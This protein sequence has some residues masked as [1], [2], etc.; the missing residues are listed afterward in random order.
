MRY[1]GILLASLLLSGA[2]IGSGSDAEAR[3]FR[4]SQTPG[5]NLYSCG[6]CHGTPGRTQFG[7][8]VQ[9]TLVGGNVNWSAI[10]DLDSDGD[11]LTNGEEM[12]DPNGEWQE[13]DFANPRSNPAD[14]NNVPFPEGALPV[15]LN[16][17]ANATE[18]TTYQGQLNAEDADG[19]TVRFRLDSSTSDG[20]LNFDEATGAFTYTPNQDY[21]GT[22][23]FVVSAI[24]GINIVEYSIA[25]VV[26]AVNDEPRVV[27]EGNQDVDEN[28]TL[29]F[30]IAGSDVEDRVPTL[31]VTDLP[32]GATFTE[33]NGQF[34]WT[35]NYEQAGD[36]TVIATATDS[37]GAVTTEE[38]V[39]TVNNVN[40][41][42]TIDELDG[43]TVG[44]EGDT[45][46][47]TAAASDIDGDN[48]TYTW[49]FG[50]GETLS[51]VNLTEVS[52]LYPVDGALTVTLTVND[53][54][55]DVT[56]THNV[57]IQNVA[58][59]ASAGINLILNEGD[60][61]TTQGSFNDP[62]IGDVHTFN[63]DFGNGTT[64]NNFIE[65]YAY[66]D[67]G[68]Y[69][70]TFTVAD[71][72]ASDSDTISVSVNNVAPT[73]S[74]GGNQTINEGTAYTFQGTFDDPGFLDTHTEV[75][76]YGN[77]TSNN[78]GQHAYADQGTFTVTYTV[79]D[80]DGGTGTDS[81]T[82][83]VNNVA[84]NVISDAVLY[85][86]LDRQYT[87]QI[88]AEDPG[89]DTITYEY[90]QGAP[91]MQMNAAGLLTYTPDPIHQDQQYTV[92]VNISDEDGGTTLHSFTLT[93]GLPDRDGDGAIDECEEAYDPLDPDDPADGPLDF[94][95]DGY[96]NAEEC[97]LGQNPI[98]SNAPS[99]PSINNPLNGGLVTANGF[100][101]AV[102][103]AQDPDGDPVTYI[104]ELY[105]DPQLS[106]LVDR[107]TNVP[108]GN[109]T[110]S[111]V[112]DTFLTEN[113]RYYWRAR[114]YDGRG[115][116]PWTDIAT[117]TFSL[118]N[119]PPETPT[120][121]APEGRIVDFPLLTVQGVEDPEGGPVFY[122]FQVFTDDDAYH[123]GIF[124]VPGNGPRVTWQANQPFEENAY[125]YWRVR[126][127]DSLGAKS[128]WTDPKRFFYNAVNTP[129]TDPVIIAP[130]D[131]ATISSPLDLLFSA[132]G[133]QD[134][135][136]DE[137]RHTFRISRDGSFAPETIIA[138]Q[139]D[140]YAGPQGVALWDLTANAAL[141][142]ENQWY[143]WDVRAR[144]IEGYSAAARAGFLYSAVNDP[145][146]K[147]TIQ[148]PAPGESFRVL[149][150]EFSWV[151]TEDPE[152]DRIFY[153]VAVYDDQELSNIVWQAVDIPQEGR[154]G[155][156]TSI[157]SDD[158]EDNK[159]YWW[160]VRAVDDKG[161]QGE[162]SDAAA[163]TVAV[164]VEPPTRP[165]LA[166][167]GND[168][169]FEIGE[170]IDLKWRNS[171]DAEG[172]AITY[173]VEVLNTSGD[174]I[175]ASGE[176]DPE[177]PTP[178]VVTT[179]TVPVALAEGSYNWRVRA[180]AQGQDSVWSN[181]ASFI[182][183]QPVEEDPKDPEEPDEPT[184]EEPKPNV[185]AAD[186]GGCAQA[187]GQ[188]MPSS[189]F[190]LFALLAG[191]VALRRRR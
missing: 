164:G 99:A 3:S 172:D 189:S 150:P 84:P 47:F 15:I 68:D 79:T 18:D 104:I 176:I 97:E 53:G 49:D 66:G 169:P 177:D 43:D 45:L 65:T 173:R 148:S 141:F 96:T 30:T 16:T 57:V 8:D 151:N 78:A 28:Q 134:E 185:P 166:G 129:P 118:I 143:T 67:N 103:N 17:E 64:R 94:D 88:L 69:T 110:T 171:T 74:A 135:D 32:E 42:P 124:S 158:L 56:A 19:D 149:N 116:S 188:G 58:P 156:I 51:D 125:Y 9:R 36:Y 12:G 128:E 4:V 107:W 175:T 2:V 159:T 182:V 111:V 105:S 77:G 91:G 63:W 62:G 174:L 163:F 184:P 13:G 152:T 24:D 81:A 7:Q 113:A 142:E 120:A 41:P 75:W 6:L 131:G 147:L 144:D 167:P 137:V 80:D 101:L 153:A 86:P 26:A 108:E 70:V 60:E 178:D 34:S 168:T 33:E 170:Q 93:V 162:W 72:A 191:L 83:T 139:A 109:F 85:A 155:D 61:F 122:D 52:Y 5:G 21:F 154:V 180:R 22:D 35:P 11:G 31:S 127:G 187:P 55:N 115:Y 37:D 44:N 89:D 10:F 126:A 54:D 92:S 27:T 160:R 133:G 48:L 114:A 117:F 190:A 90:I 100:P 73:V 145:P 157:T 112:I 20:T 186:S 102:N 161:A 121:I 183:V 76:D 38:I 95:G 25:I 181:S 50:T 138:E 59:T 46:T 23:S 165:I 1:K 140:V 39:I 71:E 119:D 106:L 136:F 179:F 146:G 87:Y 29:T 40:R 14:P 123:D 98:V 130:L 132:E 82:I